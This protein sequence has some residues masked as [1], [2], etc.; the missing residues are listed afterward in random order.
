MPKRL[1]M[2]NHKHTFPC[3][4]CGSPTRT[5]TS[6][7]MNKEKNVRINY[8]HCINPECNARFST[9]ESVERIIALPTRLNNG[10]GLPLREANAIAAKIA[11]SVL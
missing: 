10:H 4:C 8:K 3:P 5:R 7:S 9:I 1:L 11:S 6:Q 2:K